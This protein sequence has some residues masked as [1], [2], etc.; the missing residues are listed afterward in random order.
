MEFGNGGPANYQPIKV[1]TVDGGGHVT[2]IELHDG[3][4]ADLRN[5][6]IV[7]RS[8]DLNALRQLRTDLTAEYPRT[9][10]LI[11]CV[12]AQIVRCELRA[13]M[14]GSIATCANVY[15]DDKLL[16]TTR[17]RDVKLVAVPDER[18]GQDDG[19]RR[20]VE[21]WNRSLKDAEVDTIKDVVAWA[22]TVDATHM[23]TRKRI[24]I[25]VVGVSGPCEACQQRLALM[26]ETIL[27]IWAEATGQ[28]A[29]LPLLAVRSYYGNPSRGF[30]R[31]SYLVLNG[32]SG[33]GTPA[34][35]AFVNQVGW[36][37]P[38]H[39][40]EVGIWGGPPPLWPADVPTD[41]SEFEVK[42]TGL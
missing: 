30:P 18:L 32:W 41:P 20:T 16:H 33:D 27:A 15:A 38:V 10:T 22:R 6:I 4:R 14:G 21:L 3:D 8:W 35:L 19:P 26:A 39:E 31:G 25:E 9:Q 11:D 37:Q 2:P 36:H 42:L 13:M 5:E 29:P 1:M 7:R 34:N 28:T 23:I 17:M 12:Q 24:V 40:H